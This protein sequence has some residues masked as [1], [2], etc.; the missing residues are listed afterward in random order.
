MV[1]TVV[2]TVVVSVVFEVLEKIGFHDDRYAQLMG[3]D[4][5]SA[6]LSTRWRRWW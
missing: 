4:G 3:N 1:G 2:G 5:A 6:L